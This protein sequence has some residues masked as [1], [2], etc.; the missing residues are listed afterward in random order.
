MSARTFLERPLLQAK[1][2]FYLIDE[3]RFAGINF[4]NTLPVRSAVEIRILP[5]GLNEH[6][7]LLSLLIH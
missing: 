5:K 3:I 1:K 7:S 2:R 6:C 4:V